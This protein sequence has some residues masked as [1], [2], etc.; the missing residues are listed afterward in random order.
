MAV[1]RYAIYHP[2]RP[3]LPH[4][5]VMVVGAHA[6]LVGA[7]KTRAEATSIFEDAVLRREEG[8]QR[9]AKPRKRIPVPRTT[10][11]EKGPKGQKRPADVIGN[12]PWRR[13]TRSA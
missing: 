1:I 8:G 2:Q 7:G 10:N 12:V 6:V 3:E 13:S 9:R 11:A 5:V 4:L